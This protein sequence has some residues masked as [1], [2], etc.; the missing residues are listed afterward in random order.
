MGALT[1]LGYAIMIA[2]IAYEVGPWIYVDRRTRILESATSLK[3]TSM[4]TILHLAIGVALLAV[5]FAAGWFI[6]GNHA[7]S[8]AAAK[9]K[10]AAALADANAIAAAAKKL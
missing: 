2:G 1:P 4:V 6:G 10:A 7:A 8:V 5:S 9:A 3:G